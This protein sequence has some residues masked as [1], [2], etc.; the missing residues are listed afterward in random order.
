VGSQLS[1]LELSDSDSSVASI[2]GVCLDGFD[3]DAWMSD[4]DG[5]H[6]DM[7]VGAA[8]GV[9][10]PSDISWR[11][12]AWRAGTEDVLSVKV[13]KKAGV[14]PDTIVTF[15]R[16]GAVLGGNDGDVECLGGGNYEDGANL[17]GVNVPLTAAQKK[18]KKRI[19]K[20]KCKVQVPV[21]TQTRL[22]P[23]TTTS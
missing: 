2:P 17:D 10:D 1:E 4:A 16:Q 12:T 3:G 22:V 20:K 8:A 6:D 14:L 9:N 15:D 7:Q 11:T 19:Q 13:A 21:V 23:A 18:E 5:P